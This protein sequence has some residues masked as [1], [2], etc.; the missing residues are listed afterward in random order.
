MGHRLIIQST[1]P[2][3]YAVWSS[4][5]GELFMHS[6]TREEVIAYYEEQ[7]AKEA[8]ERTE[9]WLDGKNPGGRHWTPED[10]VGWMVRDPDDP[11]PED[12]R[13]AE[14]TRRM[15]AGEEVPW[16][17]LTYRQDD[18]AERKHWEERPP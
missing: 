14:V 12:L 11:C 17:E 1:D 7:A 16:D 5:T 3:L 15:L 2:L 9:R 6:A 13:R 4:V 10:A 8:R 18:P